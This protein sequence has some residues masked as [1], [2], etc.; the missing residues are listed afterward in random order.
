MMIPELW[1]GW[2]CFPGRQAKSGS[3]DSATFMRNDP[4]A[5]RQRSILERKSASSAPGSSILR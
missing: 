1:C 5:Q 4:E 2:A 3:S